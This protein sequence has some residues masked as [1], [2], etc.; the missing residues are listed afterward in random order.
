MKLTEANGRNDIII[1]NIYRIISKIV[2]ATFKKFGTRAA[3][4]QNQALL[5][6]VKNI[7]R[8]TYLD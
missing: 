7:A 6:Q 1:K 2:H 4:L 8:L 3:I 5:L